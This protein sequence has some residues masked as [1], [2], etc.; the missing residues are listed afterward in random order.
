MFIAKCLNMTRAA[1]NPYTAEEKKRTPMK[2]LVLDS[3]TLQA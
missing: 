3:L 2:N 1:S